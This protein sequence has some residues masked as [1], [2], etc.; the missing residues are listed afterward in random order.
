MKATTNRKQL[1]AALNTIKPVVPGTSCPLPILHRAL[2]SVSIHEVTITATDQDNTI[3]CEVQAEVEQAGAYTVDFKKFHAALKMCPGYTVTL[4]SAQYTLSI[5]SNG[6]TFSI[7]L[8][9]TEEFPVIDFPLGNEI[10]NT[11]LTPAATARLLTTCTFIAKERTRITLTGVYMEF[12]DG[13]LII[14][15]TDGHRL[16]NTTIESVPGDGSYIV[17]PFALKQIAK[18]KKVTWETHTYQDRI[19]FEC[20]SI[21]IMSKLIDPPYPNYRQVIPT[22]LPNLANID[23]AEL[24]AAVAGLL[25]CTNKNTHKV[26]FEFTPND[27]KLSATDSDTGATG[28]NTVACNYPFVY[29]EPITIAFNGLFII[30]ILKAITAETITFETSTATSAAIIH[31]VN[32]EDL[33]LLMPLRG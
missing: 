25:P 13:D 8:F 22:D 27:L 28:N 3:R 23:R 6:A 33:Y 12:Q 1:F 19:I 26:L 4:E 7:P 14:T 18:H 31:P 29:T 20:P 32:S 16:I 9:D 24:Q 15:A 2:I 10:S 30:D 5:T 21:M 17:P 11:L